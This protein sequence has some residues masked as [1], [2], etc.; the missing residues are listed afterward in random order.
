MRE[1][2]GL[3]LPAYFSYFKR[4]LK[5][6]A[7]P[8]G[9]LTAWRL[10]VDSG[11]WEAADDLVADVLLAVGGEVSSLN[12]DDFVQLTERTRARYLQGDGPIFAL[13]ET[14]DA[15]ISVAAGESRQ[16]TDRESELVRGIRRKTFV[17]FEE[18][19]QRD[20]KPGADPG[21]ALSPS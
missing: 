11:G 21:L 6:G 17:L 4:P 8:D 13:Y 16:L 2:P 19:L 3:V 15:I 14:I 5:V 18:Q 20:G 12:P 7:G 1:M 9:G 10:S